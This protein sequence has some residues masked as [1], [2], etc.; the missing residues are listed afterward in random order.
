MLD[1]LEIVD[2]LK[3]SAEF[4]ERQALDPDRYRAKDGIAY[5]TFRF[6]GSAPLI[7]RK[8][9][10]ITFAT[11]KN[12]ISSA[13]DQLLDLDHLN[14]AF[15]RAESTN[16]LGHLC[17]VWMSEDVVTD[18]IIPGVI[19]KEPVI[20]M[21]IAALYTKK[22]EVAEL[23]ESIKAGEPFF[24]S[25][26]AGKQDSPDIWIQGNGVVP[27]RIIPYDHAS[28]ELRMAVDRNSP[29]ISFNGQQIAYLLGGANGNI[30][31][32]GGAITR[33]PAGYEQTDGNQLKFL[34][35]TD[36]T[37]T[38]TTVVA[39][40]AAKIIEGDKKMGKTFASDE[41]YTNEVK[42]IEA[43]AEARFIAS[44]KWLAS[45]TVATTM[46]TLDEHNA[47]LNKAVTDKLRTYK[48]ETMQL[49]KD[50]TDEL[51]TLA[52]SDRF[53]YTDDGEKAFDTSCLRW[54]EKFLASASQPVVVSADKG[55][56]SVEGDKNFSP[57]SNG[58]VPEVKTLG[59]V[60][61]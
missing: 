30:S 60:W 26:E 33:N 28:P 31:Y 34:C 57:D 59:S 29:D 12:S 32:I 41:E 13:K 16:V 3:P 2:P 15:G 39:T 47:K 17:D 58:G 50:T 48:I 19:P 55:V 5:V 24:F 27:D 23:F 56:A 9:M 45:D 52:S 11:L 36:N 4:L 21:G 54:K 43:E 51:K 25:L 20:A 44:G 53:P 6:H 7:N 61:A 14:E 37:E 35:N 1:T 46:I 38:V 10:A 22:K 49:D 8:G 42:R 18:W 40:D